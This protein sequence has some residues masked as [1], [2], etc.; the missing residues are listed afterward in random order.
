MK[1]YLSAIGVAMAIISAINII[2]NT[3][4]WFNV[5]IAVVLCTAAQFAFDGLIAIIINKMPDR[6]FAVNNPLYNVSKFEQELYK[7]LKVRTW[8]DKIWELG[9]LGGFSKKNLANPNSTEYIEK[10]IIECNKG[11]LT[12]RLSYPIGFLPMLFIPNI[13]ALSIAFPVAIVNLFLNILPTLALR[14]NTPKLHA[15]LKRMN[16]N[17]KAERVEVYK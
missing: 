12:H 13:C 14:Y 6:W 3:A 7:K 17:R 15:M 9:G 11:V 10:F 5:I 2:F 1:L 4:T 16:R 8:K